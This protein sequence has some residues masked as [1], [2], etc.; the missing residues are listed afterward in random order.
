MRNGS[1]LSRFVEA[2]GQSRDRTALVIGGE[3]HTYGALYDLSGTISELLRAHHVKG[4]DRIGILTE[5]SIYTYAS[6]LAVWSC[7]ACYVPINHENP[8]ENNVS[9]VV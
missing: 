5:N 1:I 9:I 3:S 2:V 4:G 8:L 6:I 7:G